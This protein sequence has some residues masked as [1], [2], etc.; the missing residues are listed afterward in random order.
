MLKDIQDSEDTSDSSISSVITKLQSECDAMHL[1][2]SGGKKQLEETQKELAMSLYQIDA[3]KRVVARLLA[4]RDTAIK[5]LQ[6]LKSSDIGREIAIPKQTLRSS[7]NEEASSLITEK[8]SG[9]SKSRKEKKIPEWAKQKD[10][11][12]EYQYISKFTGDPSYGYRIS[13]LALSTDGEIIGSGRKNGN[14]SLFQKDKKEPIINLE[15]HSMKINDVSFVK[16]MNS[17]ISGSDDQTI[18]MWKNLEDEEGSQ[19]ILFEK[20]HESAIVSAQTHP[21]ST[22]AIS[23]SKDGTWVVY[24]IDAAGQPR[25]I[26]SVSSTAQSSSSSSLTFSGR[27][28]FE[29]ANIHP[30]GILLGT[31][32][33]NGHISIW[34][35]KAGTLV[36]DFD[37]I[38]DKLN[39]SPCTT[40]IFSE[41]GFNI[42][43][44]IGGQ[45]RV[46]DLRHSKS[47]VY[48]PL[49][50]DTLN[51]TPSDIS[52]L[53][54]AAYDNSGYYIAA[55][56]STA[57]YT[58]STKT[59]DIRATI[60]SPDDVPQE[61]VV[62]YED[63]S[64]LLVA[65]KDGS[66][67]LHKKITDLE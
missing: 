31:A 9:L 49:T 61:L 63:G 39:K 66:I 1:Q 55:C 35:L 46:W 24:D 60:P 21:V 20:V 65:K 15:G 28:P 5:T 18:R 45:L 52:I 8:Y 62:Q 7:L 17:L 25:A 53:R 32:N 16:N 51:F 56:S 58:I 3:A 43:S 33:A 42:A 37:A 29:R 59:W 26:S 40:L 48:T 27:I 19:S 57:T 50:Y 41:N 64:G 10:R 54:S 11:K 30:D 12:Y 14:I 23:A 6:E 22:L 2:I 47:G 38:G 34:D 4:E 13:A 44:V 36:A 67:D